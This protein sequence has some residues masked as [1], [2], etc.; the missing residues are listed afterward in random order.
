MKMV[1]LWCGYSQPITVQMLIANRTEEYFGIK[2][3]LE[4]V[5]Q[6][7]LQLVNTL[8]NK[9]SSMSHLQSEIKPVHITIGFWFFRHHKPLENKQLYFKYNFYP[10]YCSFKF[11]SCNQS[12]QYTAAI[13]E[14]GGL[15]GVILKKRLTVQR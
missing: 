6:S 12:F 8:E 9:Q 7:T 10:Y 3:L 1:E 2:I 11:I 4:L 14:G 15:E 13:R 5:R